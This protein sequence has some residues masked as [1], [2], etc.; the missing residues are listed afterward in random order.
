MGQEGCN[1]D[2][3]ILNWMIQ[4]IFWTEKMAF[5]DLWDINKPVLR[6]EFIAICALL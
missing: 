4:K 5:Q 3:N 2:R 6:S 1:N